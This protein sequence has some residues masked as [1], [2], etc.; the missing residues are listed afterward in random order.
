[1]ESGKKRKRNKRC[2]Y[3]GPGQETPYEKSQQYRL[4]DNSCYCQKH[5]NQSLEHQQETEQP[6][7]TNPVDSHIIVSE[8]SSIQQD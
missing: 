6:R 1:M 3:Q 2:G 8:S 5:Y 4:N 7:S